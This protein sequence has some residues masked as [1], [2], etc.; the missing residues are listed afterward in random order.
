MKT[1]NITGN[2]NFKVIEHTFCEKHSDK[3]TLMSQQEIDKNA[4][5]SDDKEK[6]QSQNSTANT[7]DP[8]STNNEKS[9]EENKV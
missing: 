7:S 3:Q 2:P 5:N 9:E 6:P 4:E 8:N 1:Y